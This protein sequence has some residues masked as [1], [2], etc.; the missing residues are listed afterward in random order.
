MPVTPLLPSVLPIEVVPTA[1]DRA[2]RQVGAAA[3]ARAVPR[4]DR[5]GHGDAVPLKVDVMPPPYRRWL[6]LLPVIV[7]CRHR[8]GGAA[9]AVADA[10]AEWPRRCPAIVQFVIGQRA[11]VVADA[12]AAAVAG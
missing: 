2:L 8:H 7:L 3:V 4:D 6:A 9:Q 10:A 5:V 1:G 12:A 11:T